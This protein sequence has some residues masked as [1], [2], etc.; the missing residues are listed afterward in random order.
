M[1]NP[2]PSPAELREE[3]AQARRWAQYVAG[4]VAERR[5]LDVANELEAKAAELEASQP[6]SPPGCADH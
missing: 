1:V 6:M 2:L 3:A 4:D 5:L